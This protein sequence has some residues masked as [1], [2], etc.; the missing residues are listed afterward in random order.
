[1][2]DPAARYHLRRGRG[3]AAAVP[4]LEIEGLRAQRRLRP[5]EGSCNTLHLLARSAA[6]LLDCAYAHRHDSRPLFRPRSRPARRRT[7]RLSA[8]AVVLLLT[9]A[10][11]PPPTAC[12][13]APA[14]RGD[15]LFGRAASTRSRSPA[16]GPPERKLASV[17]MVRILDAHDNGEAPAAV[18]ARARSLR[19]AHEH[20]ATGF[21]CYYPEVV[22]P[23]HPKERRPRRS[24]S[25]CSADRLHE[26]AVVHI[27]L[28]VGC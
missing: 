13:S 25:R 11:P 9:A 15:P 3:D 7:T 24:R 14:A 18:M 12:P 23:A 4:G 21:M 8:L 19:P 27:V 5:R 20:R 26:Q 6:D 10:S 22:S 1:M 16:R 28:Q 17:R 2:V